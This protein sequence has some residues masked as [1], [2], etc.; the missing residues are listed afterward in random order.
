LA[1]GEYF[2]SLRFSVGAEFQWDGFVRLDSNENSY[3]PSPKV[4]EAI[5]ST[6]SLVN[7]YPF[8]K[9]NELTERIASFHQVK[10]KQVLFACRPTE[11]RLSRSDT[12]SGPND[13]A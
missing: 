11:I 10:P 1:L 2:D 12:T 7:R 5:H 6:T 8:R 13:L 3:G 4:A 9:Y